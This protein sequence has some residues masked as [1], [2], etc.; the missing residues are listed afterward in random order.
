MASNNAIALM[1]DDVYSVRDRFNALAGNDKAFEKEA[2]FAIQVLQGNDYALKIATENRQSV[3]NAV[4]NIAAIGIS[5]NPARKQAYLVPRDGRICLD[6]SYMGLLDLAIQSGSLMWGQA[7]LVYEA[8]T[9]ELGDLDK[10]PTHKREPFKKDRGALVGV[11]VVVKTRDGDYL[12]TAMSI[13]EVFAIRDRSSAWKAFMKDKRKCPWVTDE[14]EMVK[15]TV[16]KR[17]YKLWPKTERSEALE[18]AI[19]YLNNEGGEGLEDVV[20]ANTTP[21]GVIKGTDGAMAALSIEVQNYMRELAGEVEEM[22]RDPERGA[23]FSFDRIEVEE[24]D[25]DLKVALWSLLPSDLRTALKQEG[26]LRRKAA[27]K[28]TPRGPEVD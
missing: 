16:I 25:S 17:A 12:T 2:G 21:A 11:Y 27:V 3:I 24:M 20:H 1:R 18:R 13:D 15:K 4:T 19:D 26:D 10:L 14:G 23:S 9:F 6:I 8:D 22:F 5:L 28:T 7:E